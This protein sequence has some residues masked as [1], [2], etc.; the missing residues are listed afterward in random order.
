VASLALFVILKIL[1]VASVPASLPAESLPGATVFWAPAISFVPLIL[2]PVVARWLI[3]IAARQPA[4]RP[5]GMGQTFAAGLNPGILLLAAIL[6]AALALVAGPRACL[7]VAL[8]GLVTALALRLARAR[9]GGVTGDVFG[10][11][12][13]LSELTILLTYAARPI[14]NL[15]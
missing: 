8:A 10:L 1:A 14:P 3:L 2:A 13:E 7:A 4:A 9:L 15:F 12:V 11:V 5:G 6:P